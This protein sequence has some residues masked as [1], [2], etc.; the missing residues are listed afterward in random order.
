MGSQVVTWNFGGLQ[1]NSQS[2]M[3]QGGQCGWLYYYNYNTSSVSYPPDKPEGRVYL[4]DVPY[5]HGGSSVNATWNPETYT[6]TTAMTAKSPGGNVEARVEAMNDIYYSFGNPEVFPAISAD[7]DFWG[8]ADGDTTVLGMHMQTQIYYNY[9]SGDPSRDPMAYY[10]YSNY[11]GP[12]YDPNFPSFM[13]YDNGEIDESG[14][15]VIGPLTLPE[16]MWSER[17]WW[18]MTTGHTVIGCDLITGEPPSNPVPEPA[19]MLLV[20]AGLVGLAGLKRRKG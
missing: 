7:W 4:T 11:G 15:L 9:Y 8:Q 1:P 5:Q 2:W 12:N 14:T 3:Q 16:G 19:T 13:L 10:A 18:T 17:G 6:T 20:G